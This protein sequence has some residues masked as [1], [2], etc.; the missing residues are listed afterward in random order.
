MFAQPIYQRLHTKIVRYI[1]PY[2]A[3]RHAASLNYAIAFIR[4]AENRTASRCWSPSTTPSSRPPCSPSVSSYQHDVEK[5]VRRFPHVRQ[6]QSWDESNRGNVRGRLISPSA[7][8][9]AL[10]LP[11]AVARLQGL[12]RHRTRRPRLAYN[13][14]PTLALHRR[15]QARDRSPQNG[16]ALDLGAA[17]LLR[18]QPPA[19]LAHAPARARAGRPGVAHRDRRDREIRPASSATSTAPVC[20]ARP[21]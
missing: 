5:F 10:L 17:Q 18:H 2:D 6:Y 12:Q 21:R 9:A 15:I 4:A 14:E 8:A 13:I 3:V 19:E 7:V 11:G 1:A 16:H 20:G